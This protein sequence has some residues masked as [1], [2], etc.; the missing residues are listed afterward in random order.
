MVLRVTKK[1]AEAR[2]GI[3]FVSA[4]VA[5]VLWFVPELTVH[6]ELVENVDFKVLGMTLFTIPIAISRV[7]SFVVWV[8][9]LISMIKISEDLKL[10][11]SR[12]TLPF[13]FG[14][15]GVACVGGLH[16]FDER[17]VAFV[18][19]V[20]AMRK[21]CEMYSMQYQV[22]EGFKMVFFVLLASLFRVEC[23]WLFLLF[24]VG[25]SV[26]QVA[27]FKFVLSALLSFVV[28]TWLLWGV[29]W[30]C[31]SIDTLFKYFAGVAD[32]KFDVLHWSGLSYAKLGFGIS[33]MILT[34][35]QTDMFSYR[36]NTH[37]K[38]N[39]VMMGVAFW[40]ALV[41][42]LVYG[43]GLL[44][45]VIFMAIESLSLYFTTDKS[46][47]SDV[48]FLIMCVILIVSRMI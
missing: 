26:Y 22:F 46:N 17:M 28:I 25:L 24:V 1:L 48:I 44:P 42:M 32:F 16:V 15:T 3:S 7:I 27:S 30:L 39:N 34:R 41:V 18:L 38:L 10:I 40:F 11:P 12:S 20:H 19:I 31:G 29:L 13:V 5:A 6:R 43:A 14:M 45:F 9:L 4:L 37:V 47:I 8:L 21:L 23:L 36:F 2:F 35:L 33:L